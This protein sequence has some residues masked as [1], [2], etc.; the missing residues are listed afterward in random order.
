MQRTF[1][2]K[3]ARV[4]NFEQVKLAAARSPAGALRIGAVLGGEWDLGIMKPDSRHV[5]V[6]GGLASEWHGKFKDEDL[7]VAEEAVW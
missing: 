6:E 2:A 7:A 4:E 3:I 5:A 1:A